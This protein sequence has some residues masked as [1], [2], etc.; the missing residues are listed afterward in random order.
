[1]PLASRQSEGDILL[2]EFGVDDQDQQETVVEDN[3]SRQFYQKLNHNK[4]AC[5]ILNLIPKI[6]PFLVCWIN[7]CYFNTRYN[8]FS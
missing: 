2:T 8:C 3:S 4:L 5:C 6:F 1:M 7:Y